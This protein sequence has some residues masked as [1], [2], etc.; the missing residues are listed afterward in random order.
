M[1]KIKES[2]DKLKEQEAAY[3]DTLKRS[4]SKKNVKKGICETDEQ[5]EATEEETK[6]DNKLN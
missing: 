1:K 4:S 6:G 5:D 3:M 2:V